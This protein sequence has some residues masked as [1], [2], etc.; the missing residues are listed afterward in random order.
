MARAIGS[1]KASSVSTPRPPRRRMTR[2]KHDR[3][4]TH[5]DRPNQ[6]GLR[7]V[8]LCRGSHAA[9]SDRPGLSVPSGRTITSPEYA[10]Q[11]TKTPEARGGIR[12]SSLMHFYT[13]P[14]MHFL[15][16]VDSRALDEILHL[17][18]ANLPSS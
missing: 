3:W 13:G 6:A 10:N 4:Q 1:S 16:G 8:T 14:P 2:P 17:T 18:W 9:H 11:L 12:C 5:F 15:S 7:D